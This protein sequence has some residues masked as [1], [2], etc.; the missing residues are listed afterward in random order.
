MGELAI[1]TVTVVALSLT[2]TSC[3]GIHALTSR[4]VECPKS[5][6]TVAHRNCYDNDPAE[7]LGA[8]DSI[9]AQVCVCHVRVCGRGAQSRG[10]RGRGLWRRRWHKAVGG[11]GGEALR[12][13]G[14]P[15]AKP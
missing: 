14:P 15:A 11:G 1:R 5:S 4:K 7:D 12:G 13:C 2:G 6:S 8:C 3:T 9:R 10:P